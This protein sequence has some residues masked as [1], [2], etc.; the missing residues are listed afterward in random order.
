MKTEQKAMIEEFQCPGCVCGGDT[1][2]D[3]F[4]FDEGNWG[5][6]CRGH[7]AGTIIV[8]I[9]TVCLGLPKGFSRVTVND[10]Q[11]TK[12]RLHLNSA[13]IMPDKLNIAVWAMEKDGFFFVRTYCPRVDISFIDVTKG[14]INWNEYPGVLDVK[15]FIDSID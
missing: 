7:V 4:D 9:G 15:E 14:K 6:Q 1:G 3:A 8:G 11:K 2:C 5:F 13:E 12:I 10:Q